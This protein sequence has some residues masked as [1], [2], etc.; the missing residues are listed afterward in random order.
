VLDLVPRRSA[1]A[2]LQREQEHELTDRGGQHAK[3]RFRPRHFEG[4]QRDD[5][6]RNHQ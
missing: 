3:A 5:R 6:D 4:E 2:G 1:Q